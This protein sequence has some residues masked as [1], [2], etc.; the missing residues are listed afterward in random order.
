MLP[1]SQSSSL[2]QLLAA[3][4]E[5]VALMP[6]F[7]LWSRTRSPPWARMSSA[8]RSAPSPSV[9]PPRLSPRAPP[10][11]APFPPMPLMS[12]SS[13]AMAGHLAVG[14]GVGT[15]DGGSVGRDVGALVGTPDGASVGWD[16]GVA[17]GTPVGVSVG[18]WDC[19]AGSI[20]R[21]AV[22]TVVGTDVGSVVGTD[23][24]TSVGSSVGAAVVGMGVGAGVGDTDGSGVG[25]PV[26][27]AV[28]RGIVGSLVGIE[29]G[30]SV[31]KAVI[32]GCFV[33]QDVGT[34][35]GHRASALRTAASSAPRSGLS[36]A[37]P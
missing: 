27:T 14:D 9:A 26:G 24:G 1:V 20:G 33:G 15:R 23:D 29:V 11:R 19:H 32:W 3:L 31:G 22:G 34:F 6:Q 35:D 30:T 16:V 17:V 4:F 7:L 25:M 21:C 37:P 5:H 28:G 10:V 13:H 36:S 2:S 18:S 8:L 12:P